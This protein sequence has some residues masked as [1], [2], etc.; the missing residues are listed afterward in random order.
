MY[1]TYAELS[2][3][4]VNFVNMM[5]RIKTSTEA[6]KESEIGE[7]SENFFAEK[8]PSRS[9]IRRLSSVVST[10]SSVVIITYIL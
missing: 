4:N 8:R 7:A 9:G 5:N 1:G 10:N 6:R 2:K 3:F